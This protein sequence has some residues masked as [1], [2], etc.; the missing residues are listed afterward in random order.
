MVVSYPGTFRA[1]AI[2]SGSYATCLGP[3]CEIPS[4]LPSDHP[5]TLFL[6]GDADGTVPVDTAIA[7]RDALE[8]QGIETESIIDMGIGH[9]WLERA[10]EA[11]TQW[12]LAH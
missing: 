8:A 4:E 3:F 1:L 6:H 11:I 9:A 7:Y 2:Q 12:F 5:P 10:P